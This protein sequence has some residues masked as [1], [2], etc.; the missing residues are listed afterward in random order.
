MDESKI[1]LRESRIVVNKGE[2]PKRI[3]LRDQGEGVAQRY[4]THVELLY[5]EGSVPSYHL[6]Y[7]HQGYIWG[8]YFRDLAQAQADY[9]KRVAEM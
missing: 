7:K 2:Q 8:H 4:V 9:A 6:N 5:P 1:R 3:V